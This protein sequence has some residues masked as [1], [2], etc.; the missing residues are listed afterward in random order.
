M[1]TSLDTL[2]PLIEAVR[3]GVE[4]SGW[5]LSG[6][7]KTT[8]YEFE[9]R[10]EG[11]A[12]RSAYLFF[13]H[14]D[15]GE[16]SVDVY[17]DETSRGLRGNLA[18]VIDLRAPGDLPSLE[19]VLEACASIAG[20]FLPEGYRTPVTLRLRLA[21]RDQASSEA[22]IETRL[23][24]TLPRTAIEAGSSAVSAL[25]ASTVAAFDRLLGDERIRSWR[26]A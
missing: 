12:T 20:T 26:R 25:C 5:T 21:D 6:L 2:E 19:H 23:K 7:Q 24:L 16:V 18:L 3:H 17:L 8:S 13:H 11:D 15:Q 10:W 22:S 4:E 1:H 14:A 9:G